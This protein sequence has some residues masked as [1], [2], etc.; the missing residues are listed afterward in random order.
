VEI[1]GLGGG[2]VLGV[3]GVMVLDRWWGYGR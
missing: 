1:L 2:G 3:M